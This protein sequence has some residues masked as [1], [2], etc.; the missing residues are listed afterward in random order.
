MECRVAKP[1]SL[2]A[3]FF[4]SYVEGLI[5]WAEV[6]PDV[7]YDKWRPSNVG[8]A[9]NQGIELRLSHRVSRE[10]SHFFQYST[11]DSKG[12]D[13]G[14]INYETLMYTP[15]F[16]WTY[17][18]DYS[19]WKGLGFNLGVNHCAGVNWQDDWGT[20]HTLPAYTL[21]NARISMKTGS[22]EWF[23]AAQNLLDERYQTREYYPLPGVDYSAGII[24]G[25]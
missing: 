24:W 17:T 22:M 13:K 1:I 10:I 19:G 8:E 3:T 20:S 15:S 7:E 6:D 4:K 25:L 21:V 23:V 18:F 12:R 14:E 9:Y 5:Q 2:Q 16:R 11:L